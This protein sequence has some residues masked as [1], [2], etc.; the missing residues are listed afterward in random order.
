VIETAVEGPV[1]RYELAGWRDEFGLVA[2]ITRRGDADSPFDLGLGGT[3]PAGDVLDR[4][5]ALRRAVPGFRAIVVSR[6][7]HGT[8]VLWHDDARGLVIHEGFD[9][10]ATG[11]TGLLLAVT[12]ADC[13][14]VYLIDPVRRLVAI[15]HAGWRGTAAGVLGA[16][17]AELARRGSSV[18]N[19]L[20]HCGVG[21]CGSCYEV[22]SEVFAGCGRPAPATGRGGLDLRAVLVEQARAHGV[23]RVSTSQFCSKHDIGFFSHRGGSGARMAAYLGLR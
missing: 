21:I 20:V 15:L 8:G 7:V 14:P 12:V 10:H 17:L 11:S 18:E 2:G 6:Q 9:G 1:P 19:V 22:G 4:W 3:S 13:I 16:G 23:D 5:G